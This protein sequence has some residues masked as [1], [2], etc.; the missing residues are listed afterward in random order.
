MPGRRRIRKQSGSAL[1]LVATVDLGAD[2]AEEATED[3]EEGE[4]EVADVAGEAETAPPDPA[5]IVAVAAYPN[6]VW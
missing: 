5:W 2:A 4:E 1:D 3:A 6:L